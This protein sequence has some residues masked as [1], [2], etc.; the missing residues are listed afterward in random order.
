MQHT[1]IAIVYLGDF[2]FDARCINMALSLK[3][4]NAKIR[5]DAINNANKKIEYITPVIIKL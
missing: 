3:K 5:A 1:N 2:F 4:E